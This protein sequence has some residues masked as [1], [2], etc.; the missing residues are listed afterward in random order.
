VVSIPHLIF[1]QE[2][3][4]VLWSLNGKA[5]EDIKRHVICRFGHDYAL[6]GISTLEDIGLSEFPVNATHKIIKL[7]IEAAVISSL[8]KASALGV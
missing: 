2:P 5:E 8:F 3:F 4:A 1:G 6:G 7:D